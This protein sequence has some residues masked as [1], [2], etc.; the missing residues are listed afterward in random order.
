[1]GRTIAVDDE[2]HSRLKN[3]GRFG[4][5][6]CD[7]IKRLLDGAEKDSSTVEDENNGKK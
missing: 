6:Y 4:D 7:I 1:M 2:T 5:S 3:H